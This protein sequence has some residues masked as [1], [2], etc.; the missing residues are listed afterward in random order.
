MRLSR[1]KGVCIHGGL[2]INKYSD[3]F[4]VNGATLDIGSLYMNSYSSVTAQK[5]ITIGKNVIM[6][7]NV[8][9][10]DHNHKFEKA[11]IPFAYQ[12]FLLKEV[13]IGNNC[14]IGSG[15]II[16][17]GAYIGDNCVI[18]AGCIINGYIPDNSIVRSD[19]SLNIEPIKYK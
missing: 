18:G 15:S 4:V 1:L 7:H 14:W 13:H 9:V 8:H 12:G 2:T 11:D 19:R 17:A 5:K 16:L 10:Y 3:I 6:G